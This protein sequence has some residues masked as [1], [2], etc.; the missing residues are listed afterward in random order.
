MRPSRVPGATTGLCYYLVYI[1]EGRE[2]QYVRDALALL[3]PEF[4]SAVGGGLKGWGYWDRQG[5]SKSSVGGWMRF[6]F[7][8][9]MKFC[10][11]I[12]FLNKLV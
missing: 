2:R 5:R 11:L 12:T 8:S 3:H 1:E 7:G 6:C 4:I 10:I 9:S